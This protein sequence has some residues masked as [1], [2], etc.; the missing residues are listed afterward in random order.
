MKKSMRL[1]SLMVVAGMTIGLFAHYPA[2]PVNAAETG[3]INRRQ[4]R[5]YLL[6]TFSLK[7]DERGMMKEESRKA[8]RP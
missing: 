1:K 8:L 7:K 2:F 3:G 6:R 5:A 4:R